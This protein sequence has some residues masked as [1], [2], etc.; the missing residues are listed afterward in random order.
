MEN[1]FKE[2]S[3]L[4]DSKKKEI[5]VNFEKDFLRKENRSPKLKDLEKYNISKTDIQNL[6]GSLYKLHIAAGINVEAPKIKRTNQDM[7]E[8]LENIAQIDLKTDCWVTDRLYTNKDNRTMITWKGYSTCIYRISYMVFNGSLIDGLCIRH[9]CDNE[10]CFNPK[11][12]IQGTAQENVIDAVTRKRRSYGQKHKHR[13]HGL[14]NLYDYDALLVFVKSRIIVTEKNEWLYDGPIGAGGYPVISFNGK[15]YK[16]HRLILANKLGIKYEDIN[17]ACHIFPTESSFYAL[18]PAKHDVNPDHL[19]NGTPSQNAID[20]KAYNKNFQLSVEDV[21]QIRE[22]AKYLTNA[23][24]FDIEMAKKFDVSA[25]TIREARL[26]KTYKYCNEQPY[27]AKN[28]LK[29]KILQLDM[30][31]NF[32]KEWGSMSEAARELKI[33]VSGISFACNGKIKYYKNFKWRLAKD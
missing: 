26:G 8:Y 21:K 12:L 4:D 22:E 29:L 16:L 13:R 27:N 30:E 33:D 10:R 5:L 14:T 18:A 25:K 9:S 1:N 19:Y 24:E 31:E 28:A 11:H 3:S 17:L 2:F 23:M 15:Q 20:T 6:F 7:R 32:I